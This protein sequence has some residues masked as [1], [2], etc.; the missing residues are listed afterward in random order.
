MKSSKTVLIRWE[1]PAPF[2]ELLNQ[3]ELDINWTEV[4]RELGQD[5]VDWLLKQDR[6]DCQLSLEFT[7]SGYKQLIAEF[8]NKKI[9]VSYHLMWA[10]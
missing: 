1:E 9:A 7:P 2:S 6:A 10:K 3:E 8:F 4:E 5:C